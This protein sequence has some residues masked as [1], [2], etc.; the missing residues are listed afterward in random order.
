MGILTPVGFEH[1]VIDPDPAGSENDVCLIADVDGDGYN[2][3]IIGG[4]QGEGNLVWYQYPD[5]TR[6][7]IATASLEAGGVV[8]D[9]TGS[10]RLDI[11]AGEHGTGKELY[12]FENPKNPT[13]PW[14]KRVLENT[15]EKY[16]DQAVGDVDG[17]GKDELVILSQ[18]A[19]VLVYYD[20]PDDPT[21]EPWPASCRHVIAE[22]VK[23]EG[24]VIVDIDH[25]G[26]QEILAGTYVFK[27]QGDPTQPW[28][29]NT[30][31]DGWK[32]TRVTVGDINCDGDL[33][34]IYSECETHPGRLAWFEGPNFK[35]MHVMAEDLFHAHSLALADFNGDGWVDI[36]VA[37]MGLGRCPH[38]P[39]MIVYLNDGNGNFTQQVISEGVPNHEAKVGDI[40]NKGI[41]SI[42]GKPYHPENHVDLWFNLG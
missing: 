40:G 28:T 27:H 13:R 41:L 19:K 3:V 1:K 16:H 11:V 33:D 8:A 2:D 32:D 34:I 12:W 26:H 30:V 42:V 15:F 22:D 24:L 18:G 4:K 23:I 37:E 31:V 25:D 20:I 35:T 29:K 6:H 39:R 10:G 5:W 17:D 36:F 9:L 14:K 21:Q 7:T 38:D